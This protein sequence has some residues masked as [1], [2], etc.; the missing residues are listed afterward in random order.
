MECFQVN[1]EKIGLR[2]P[3]DVIITGFDEGSFI[4][5]SLTQSASPEIA[6]SVESVQINR[7]QQL[8]GIDKLPWE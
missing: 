3:E 7:Y 1:I 6:I 4:A 2:V 8:W 5:G